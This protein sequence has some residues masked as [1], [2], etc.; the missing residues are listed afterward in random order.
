MAHPDHWTS[1][2]LAIS[3]VLGLSFFGVTYPSQR[4]VPRGALTTAN[5]DR[6]PMHDDAILHW[7]INPRLEAAQWA[8]MQQVLLWACLGSLLCTMLH[9]PCCLGKLCLVVRGQI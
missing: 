7:V 5:S 1:D 4:L 8:S 9:V 3:F 6:T 2:E